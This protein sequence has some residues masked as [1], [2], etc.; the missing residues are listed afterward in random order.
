MHFSALSAGAL[1][2][3][4]ISTASVA[5]AQE[6]YSDNFLSGHWS[7]TVGAAGLVAPRFDGSKDWIFRISP[8]VSLSRN[9]PEPLFSSRNDSPSFGFVDTGV[10]RAGPAGK[11]VFR[12]DGDTDKALRGLDPIRFGV[13]LGGFAEV[14]PSQNIRLRGEVRRGIRS[15]DGLVAD[16]A[17]DV[18]DDLS[19]TIRISGG[20]RLSF[21]N[22]DYFDAYYGISATE[23]ARSGLPRYEPGGGI[24]SV[25][26][27][28]A[29]TWMTTEKITTSVFS[30]YE[31]LVG[32]AAN[33]PLVKRRGSANQFTVGVSATY[34][35]DFM[36][37]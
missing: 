31:R 9:G 33:S 3:A 22:A 28:A 11:L 35:F 17:L 27:G 13:E 14:Y 2:L 12:R 18:F 1:L 23:S 37:D 30:E 19:S 8:M 4:G 24:K 16:V 34:R 5:V 29:I 20:P 10:F 36:V 7:L 6:G 32:P 25:G 15:H 21:A 26:A